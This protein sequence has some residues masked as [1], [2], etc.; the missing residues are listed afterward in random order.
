MSI[1]SRGG[2]DA[3]NDAIP[4]DHGT[5]PDMTSGEA[6][7]SAGPGVP[8]LDREDAAERVQA[9][10]AAGELS[11]FEADRLTF[12][13]REGYVD[14]G[15][16][17]PPELCD[18]VRGETEALMASH[19]GEPMESWLPEL[20]S[21]FTKD[22]GARA[23]TIEPALLRWIDLVL[24]HRGH[25]FQTLSTPCGTQIPGHS[26][27]ILMTTDPPG[28]MVAAWVALE[29]VTPEVGP[30][31][32]WPGSHRLPYLS[33]EELGVKDDDDLDARKARHNDHYY[34]MIAERVAHIA[35][36]PYLAKKGHVLLW[37][38][39][40]VHGGSPIAQPGS[41]RHSLVIHFYAEGRKSYSDLFARENPCP[42]DIRPPTL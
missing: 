24:G 13:A 42:A 9:R 22:A 31:Q 37:H 5:R 4:S 26:D 28:F 23:L 1:P 30:V 10:E 12:F 20:E 18:R 27:A 35:P 2:P 7:A 19:E 39:N 34:P 6:N 25:P 14:L 40:L 21:R 17:I 29:D 32:V 3:P 15:P 16:V 36:V 8:W 38:S 33:A 11:A 41:S